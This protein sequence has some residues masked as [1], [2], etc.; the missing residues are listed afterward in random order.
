[1]RD[2][3]E[4]LRRGVY[5]CRARRRAKTSRSHESSGLASAIRPNAC[6]AWARPGASGPTTV[7][8]PMG[9]PLLSSGAVSMRNDPTDEP[10]VVSVPPTP[11]GS[12]FSRCSCWRSGG[13]SRVLKTF[14]PTW[15]DPM[16]AI[17]SAGPETPMTRR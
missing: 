5:G 3:R 15:I 17:P 2:R 9:E 4:R 10:T 11:G 12:P 8:V 13:P 16:S 7:N 1:M 6:P 14:D